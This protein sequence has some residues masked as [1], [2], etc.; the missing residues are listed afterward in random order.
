[1]AAVRAIR[2]A[3]PSTR[4]SKVKAEFSRFLT[5]PLGISLS[6]YAGDGVK[7]EVWAAKGTLCGLSGEEFFISWR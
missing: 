7:A 1:M 3:W 4:V 6:A 2:L 5:S